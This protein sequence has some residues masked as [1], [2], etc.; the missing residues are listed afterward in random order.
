MSKISIIIPTINEA[1]NLPLLLSDLSSIQKEGEIIIV[2]SGSEDK[3]I[4]IANIYGAKVFISKERN[5]GLQLDIGAKNSTGEWLIFLHADTRLTHDWFKKINSF[6]EGNK[7]IIYYFEFKINHKKIIYRFL[8]ILVNI[9][10]KF[11]KQPYGDQG[12]II[13]RTIY[14]KNNGFRNIPLMEDVDFLMRLNKKKDLKQLNFPIFISSRKWERTNI[15]LQA[16]KNWHFRR[17]W[18]K[19]ESLKSIYSDYY[20]ND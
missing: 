15:F 17:R 5:R 8:E 19:G 20:K 12:L 13:H 11:F 10:S 6:L 14:F 9:R 7:N 16:I 1:S 4:D 18:L 2:D 3:T